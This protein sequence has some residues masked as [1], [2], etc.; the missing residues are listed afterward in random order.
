M[1][2]VG[3]SS[4]LA[5]PYELSIDHSSACVYVYRSWGR[6]CSPILTGVFGEPSVKRLGNG[7]WAMTYLNCV[8]G[9]IVS[10]HSKGPEG[11]WSDEKVQVTFAQEPN[12]YGGFIHPVCMSMLCAPSFQLIYMHAVCVIYHRQW[13]DVGENNLHMMISKWSH[14]AAGHSTACM[15]Y[16]IASNC[17][18][19]WT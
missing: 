5:H 9:C 14:D 2:P 3:N 7:T 19:Y 1:V 16:C 10:R 6:P 8:T 15:C 18:V 4:N 11:L 13:S 17:F 12:L